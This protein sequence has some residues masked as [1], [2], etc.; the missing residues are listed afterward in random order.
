MKINPYSNSYNSSST[1]A[2]S[3]TRAV[4]KST[5]QQTRRASQAQAYSSGAAG[6][7]AVSRNRKP[8]LEHQ[9]R[10]SSEQHRQLSADVDFFSSRANHGGQF[11]VPQTESSAGYEHQSG[12]FQ[13]LNNQLMTR[14]VST[15]RS[16]QEM[17]D[18]QA[19]RQAQQKALGV[20][21]YA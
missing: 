19:L 6:T 7:D 5:E 15:Y 20:D 14:A 18:E 13:R 2:S 17:D 12:K 1:S 11:Y 16:H 8:A 4:A 3:P 10:A 9:Q 21:T